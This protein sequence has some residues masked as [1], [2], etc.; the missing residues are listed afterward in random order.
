[1]EYKKYGDTY[2]IRMDKGDE[3]VSGLLDVCKK[4]NITSCTYTG[5]GGCS[6]ADIQTFVPEKGEFVSNNIE[7]L[8]EL[9]SITGNII[10]DEDGN[11]YSHSHAMFAYKEGEQH[12]IAAGHLKSTVVLYT[13][14]ITLKPVVDGNIGREYNPETG[15]G[16]WKF[17]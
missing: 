13:A 17:E 5:I 1:M 7:G 14:E 3:V 9:V 15:T 2:Y 12:K 11:L 6:A 8:L 16:F 10:S 4:E